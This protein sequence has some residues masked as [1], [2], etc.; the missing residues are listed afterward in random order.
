MPGRVSEGRSAPGR[1]PGSGPPPDGA[2][3]QDADGSLLTVLAAATKFSRLERVSG[4]PRVFLALVESLP[5]TTV[6][7]LHDLNLAAMLPWAPRPRCSPAI[8]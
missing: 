3:D 5:V 7:A 6:I 8:P 2:R 4:R 1:L